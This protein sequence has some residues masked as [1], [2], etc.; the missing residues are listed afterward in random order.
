M[1]RLQLFSR[2]SRSR[3]SAV[4][5]DLEIQAVDFLRQAIRMHRTELTTY[6]VIQNSAPPRE[7]N[8]VALASEDMD[9]RCFAEHGASTGRTNAA[10][11]LGYHW[12]NRS[13]DVAN[14]ALGLPTNCSRRE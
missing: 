14:R 5:N 13:T 8:F 6:D 7:F 3:R 4:K 1:H 11:R 9:A 10:S 2:S 12:R